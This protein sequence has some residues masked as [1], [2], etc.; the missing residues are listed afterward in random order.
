M[1]GRRVKISDVWDDTVDVLR[2]R[3]GILAGI[4]I[5]FVL[6]PAVLGNAVTPFLP[7]MTGGRGIAALI[8]IV[9]TV[10]LLVGWLAITAVASDPAV[11]RARGIATGVRR[12]GP[13]LACIAAF[14]VAAMLAILPITYLIFASGATYNTATGRI[15]LPDASA[16]AVATTGFLSIAIAIFMLW[17]TA[18]LVPLFAVI[19]NERLGL[20]AFARSF[21]LTRGATLRLVAVLLLYIVVMAVLGMAATNVVGVVARLLLGADANAAVAFVVATVGSVLTTVAAT[22][23]VVFST[24]YYLSASASGDDGGASYAPA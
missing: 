4:A 14:V 12:L 15:R 3:A 2:G 9:V 18:R 5:L 13:T 23:Q 22:V 17:L 11:D 10:L 8:G 1:S 21:G 19:V 24:R 20:R 7:G 6:L 16:G